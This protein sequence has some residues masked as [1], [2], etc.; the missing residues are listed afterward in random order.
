MCEGCRCEGC[1]CVGGQ[2]V[3]QLEE[4]LQ[5]RVLCVVMGG[6]CGRGVWGGVWEGSV[7]R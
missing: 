4:F 7:E 6:E 3:L 5:N 2:S 1:R